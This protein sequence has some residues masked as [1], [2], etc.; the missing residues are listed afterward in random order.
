MADDVTLPGTGA[1]IKTDDV[2]GKQYQVVKLDLGGDGL[3]APVV[4]TLPVSGTVTATGPLTDT[5][6]R[7]SAVPVSF[8]G[9]SVGITGSVAVTGTFWQAT[10]PVSAASLPLPT[11]AATETTLAAMN[12]KLPAA[13]QALMAASQPVVIA[14]DQSI[15]PVNQA[16][17]SA[18]GSLAAL[19]AAVTLS[20]AGATG[21]AVDVRGTFV[22]TILIQGT[23]DG[24]NWTTLSVLPVGAGLNIA[25]VASVTAAGAWW[26]NAN[27]FQ[28]IRA[29]ASAYT[30]GSATVVLRAMQAAGM[31]YSLPTGQTTVAVCG[32]VTANIGTGSIAAGTNAIGDVG[33]QYRTNATGAATVTNLLCPATPAVQTIKGGAGRLIA[34]SMTNTNASSRW[35]KVWNTASGGITLGTTAA[36]FEVGIPP[37]QHV[38]FT[39]EGGLA[40]G[41]A[42]NIAITGGQ[43][44]TN[45][46]AVTSGDVTGFTAHA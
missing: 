11:G 21:F 6:L 10:Q 17:V 33:V 1:V 22:A 13:G 29:T 24:T 43:G 15:V 7:A 19:N 2:S 31:V 12:T 45:N 35:L 20:L 46:T 18:T 28:Q 32:T 9:Q 40:F 14:S 41:T 4:G 38:V 16:G 5:Q 26:G 44:L 39:I 23:I 42:I 8:S 36:L 30:S 3:S 34:V 25:Q 27:G 37:N